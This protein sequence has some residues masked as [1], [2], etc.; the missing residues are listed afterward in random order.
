M[1][2]TQANLRNL[3]ERYFDPSIRRHVSKVSWF[4]AGDGDHFINACTRLTDGVLFLT[5]GFLI[6]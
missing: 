5:D 3:S 4:S 1:L 6:R 2:K